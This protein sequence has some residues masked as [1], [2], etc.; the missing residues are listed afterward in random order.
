MCIFKLIFNREKQETIENSIFRFIA[1][2]KYLFAINR[3][4]AFSIV[5]YA[6]CGWIS[7]WKCTFRSYVYYEKIRLS[8]FELFQIDHEFPCVNFE[9]CRANNNN[10]N[11]NMHQQHIN[12]QLIIIIIIIIIIISTTIFVMIV[13]SFSKSS[14]SPFMLYASGLVSL[15]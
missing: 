5:S 7:I 8:E 10:N 11:N 12:K 3:N 13:S 6:F 14:S 15:F 1:K 4:I 9:I 2:P